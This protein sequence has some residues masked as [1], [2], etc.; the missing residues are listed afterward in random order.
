MFCSS[1]CKHIN[2]W[3]KRKDEICGKTSRKK[4]S[5]CHKHR[6]RFLKFINNIYKSFKYLFEIQPK[7]IY[8]KKN[9]Q[10]L[11]E[12]KNIEKN[13]NMFEKLENEYKDVLLKYDNESFF[14]YINKLKNIT[15]LLLL[16][17]NDKLVYDIITK[18][19]NK[20]NTYGFGTRLYVDYNNY[21]LKT[22]K[23]VYFYHI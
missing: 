12:Q 4:D 15:E 16:E 5:R 23:R 14:Y 17:Y 22:I 2:K 18:Y 13:K 20:Y 19:K 7:T 6:Y 8:N 1:V 10:K 3:G 21:F 11:L 9:V